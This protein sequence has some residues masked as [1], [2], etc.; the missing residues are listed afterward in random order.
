MKLSRMRKAS[1]AA[2][3]LTFAVG[4]G[5]SYLLATLDSERR[6]SEER[7]AALGELAAVRAQLEG[8][9]K[10]TFSSTDG[11]VHLVAIKRGMEADLF[12]RMARLA[13]G[14][15]PHIRN[16][17]L[18]PDEVVKYLWPPAGNERAIGFA[19]RN[20]PEQYR[21]VL[22]ARQTR[23]SVLA[24]PV[25]LIQGG[26]GFINRTPVF[27][28]G[29][30]DRYWG[31]VSI[32]AHVDSLLAAGGVASTERLLIALRGK[33]GRGSKG[34]MIAGDSRV[35]AGSPVTATVPIP[36]GEWQ[37]GA[38]PRAGWADRSPW[39]SAYFLVGMLNTLLLTLIVGALALQRERMRLNHAALLREMGERERVGRA[40]REEQERFRTLFESSPDP[41]W[42]IEDNRFVECNET[43]ARMLGY[44]SKG[45]FLYVHP[46]KLSPE[47]Q[48]DGE[49]SFTKAERLMSLTREHGI[50]RFEWIHTRAN[51]ENFPAE[52]TLCPIVLQGREA[53]Y[54]TWRDISE[55]KRAEEDLRSSQELLKAVIDSAGV[56]IYAF[57]TEGRLILCNRQFEIAVGHRREQM[58]GKRRGEFMPAAT[59][60]QHEGN[61]RAVIAGGSLLEFEEQNI[62]PDG[63]RIY[64]T[65]KCPV[66]VGGALRAVVGVSADITEKKRDDERL[67]LAATIL[68]TTA[69]GVVV[70]DAAG[71]I[72][73]VNRAF[74]E[75]TGYTEEEVLG[76]NPRIL[77]S[78]RHEPDFYQALWKSLVDVGVWQGEIWNRRR[79]GE[80]F[81]EWQT[82][83]AIRDEAGRTTHYVS[84][85]S[86]ISSL[87]RS[88]DELER[89][90]RFDPLTDL[91]NRM[92]FQDRLNH[93]IDRAQRYEHAI[94]VLLLDLDGFKTVNDSLGHPVG[95]RLLQEVAG[96]LKSCIRVEDTVSRLGGDEFALILSSMKEGGDAVEV[97][98]KIL[99]AIQIPVE[100][101]GHAAR[102][103]ASI[104]IAVY[105]ADG[106]SVTDLVRNADAAMYSAKE[107]GRNGY[108]FYQS[109]MTQRAQE[110]LSQERALRRGIENGEFEVWFQPQLALHDGRVTGAEALVRWRDPER[111]L[112][113]PAQFVPLAERTGLIV[114]IGAQVLHQV[115][116]H[117]RRWLDA[118][119]DFGRLAINVAAPQIER[120]DFAGLLSAALARAGVPPRCV[121]IEITESLLMENSSHA[122]ETLLAV[123][124][125]GVTTA[126]D[127]FG[128][129]YSSLAYLKQLPIDNLKI[130]R[131]FVKDLPADANDVAI[132]RAIISMAH[133]LGFTVIAEGIETEAQGR[134]LTEAGCDEGQG[135]LF[136]RPLPAADFEAWL[137]ARHGVPS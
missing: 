106:E 51:G 112:V 23:A 6:A 67:R 134:F 121:E 128:T 28:G 33:D 71:T 7:S 15:N 113:A 9:V 60:A 104:G 10:A 11:L 12:D 32:V 136:S 80:A 40:L 87:K 2:A 4:F 35:F 78:E 47:F 68:A 44:P 54:C 120:Q 81:P 137:I 84:V 18:A 29:E 31:V 50:N 66:I 55:R 133:S 69:E 97:V 74:T 130:D 83:T 75:I 111:G 41:V 108:R 64:F 72:L 82:I 30:S 16:I 52:V 61:D 25:D 102:V 98:R 45:D 8:V 26:R 1:V 49:A 90:A 114:E 118:G 125:L 101:Y 132:T 105:P 48:P 62:E 13:I 86:D 59:A 117:A 107:A 99:S 17:A 5:I 38:I 46:S 92:L 110:R 21:T 103:T 58:L 43:A 109:S 3:L 129:G 56:V 19:Y 24:G 22:Q 135:Y 122:R 39:R 42:I 65:V 63:V 53:I 34:A 57:D 96:R 85:F 100:L 36:G 27:L 127:D 126:I 14:K 94:A 20:S 89:L 37:L 116:D 124:A 88:Q 93:A 77:R 95:D 91:P 115:C 70:T 73:S 76:G 123:Q 79:S 131:A 119:L